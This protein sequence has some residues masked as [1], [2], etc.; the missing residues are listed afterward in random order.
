M[1]TTH[2]P[3]QPGAGTPIP[4]E[5]RMRLRGIIARRFA[6]VYLEAQRQLHIWRHHGGDEA[7]RGH[8]KALRRCERL[9]QMERSLA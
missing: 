8:V 4:I 2:T 7:L 1:S 3:S 5:I 6:K 9:Q